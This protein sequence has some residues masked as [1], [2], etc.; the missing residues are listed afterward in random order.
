MKGYSPLLMSK[1]VRFEA[2]QSM[3]YVLLP[4]YCSKVQH[5]LLIQISSKNAHNFVLGEQYFLGGHNNLV[6]EFIANI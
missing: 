5:M 2:L 1:L 6:D 4:A 3:H